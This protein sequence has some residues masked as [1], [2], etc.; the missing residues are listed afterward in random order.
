M[1][2]TDEIKLNSTGPGDLIDI[3]SAISE[4]VEN[5]GIN[6]G[7][8][9]VFISGSTAGLTTLEYEPGL[10]KDFPELMEQLVPSNRAYQHDHTWH[11]GN[12]FSHLRS[13][14]IGTSLT[15]PFVKGKLLL[16]QWQQATFCEFD[17]RSRS[18]K[19]VFQIIGE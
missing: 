17:N 3:T 16:G 8:V 10:V 7:I 1:V 18:R 15:I 14:L 12:G 11:D 9:T 6:S 2:K 13:A 5:S 4:A 19:V